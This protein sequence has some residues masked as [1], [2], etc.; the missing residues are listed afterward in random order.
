MDDISRLKELLK[1]DG[2][3]ILLYHQDGDGVCSAAL[4]LKFYKRFE[5]FSR[6][7]PVIE[8][9]FA[10]KIVG[11][12][13][14][15]IVSLDIPLDQSWEKVVKISRKIPVCRWVIIDH[16]L[17]TKDLNSEAVVHINQRFN[18][19]TAY[20]PVSCL[21]YELLKKTG[22][23]P[24]Q[25][26]W[27]SAIGTVADHAMDCMNLK[28][29]RRIYPEL[30]EAG[31]NSKIKL[32]SDIISCLIS[33]KEAEGANLALETM[34]RAEDFG[35]FE[36]RRELK[37]VKEEVEG[38]IQK[39]MGMFEKNKEEYRDIGLVMFEI[40]TRLGLTAVVNSILSDIYDDMVIL[41]Y[42]KAG[43]GWKV[44]LRCQ[45]GR[46]NMHNLIRKCLGEKDSGGGHE[47]AGGG[48]I[49]DI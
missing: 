36:G 20:I 49:Y 23:N 35:F 32:G 15:L 47:K 16:H 18:D 44:S 2:K 37:K 8:D 6:K 4:F 26:V 48:L 45:S 17:I 3:K 42:K 41:V 29:C 30:F 19:K 5:V 10:K 28:E 12:K 9:D 46:V 13:P 38:E 11:M 7:G 27:I 14:A 21:L 31:A 39:I 33:A 43:D 25:H 40:K 24:E 22:K 1:S 34:V